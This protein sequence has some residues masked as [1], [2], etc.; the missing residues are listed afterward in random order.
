MGLRSEKGLKIPGIQEAL[1]RGIPAEKILLYIKAKYGISGID[2]YLQAGEKPEKVLEAINK[3]WGEPSK[4]VGGFV[5]NIGTS[6]KKLSSGMVEAVLEHP[7]ATLGGM[8]NLAEGIAEYLV[9]GEQGSEKYVD[10]IGNMLMDRYGSPKKAW[11]SFYE[12][13]VGVMSDISMV[14]GGL[15]TATGAAGKVAELG[16]LGK[17]GEVLGGVSKV[18]S[19]ASAATDPINLG[20]TAAGKLAAKGKLAENLYESALKP[21]MSG[22]KIGNTSG[23]IRTGLKEGIPVSERGLK[24]IQQTIK[25]LN[26]GIEESIKLDPNY[27]VSAKAVAARTGRSVREF[28]KQPIAGADID[29]ISAVRSQFLAEHTTPGTI[30]ASKAQ[31]M[32]K[33]A[34]KYLEEKYEKFGSAHVEAWKDIARGLKEELESRFPEIKAPNMREGELIELQ[35]ELFRA[36]RRNARKDVLPWGSLITGAATGIVTKELGAAAVAAVL[37]KTLSDPV[38]RSKLAIAINRA[39]KLNPGKFRAA[40]IGT[41]MSRINAY[42]DD[43]ATY[44]QTT[45][46]AEAAAEANPEAE[47]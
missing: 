23:L 9:P 6:T 22:S 32:K 30:P 38:L 18:A 34:Y 40:R 27:P 14:L 46:D 45:A 25:K 47:Q 5:E 4:S 10:A 3:A 2:D 12:D 37:H 39:Q 13:P 17:T 35:Q 33:A 11:N 24:R 36:V 29:E 15:G 28:G 16:K 8:L 26:K 21:S 44:I 1:N 19:A 20:Y 42:L 43:L 41:T 31:E 7:G